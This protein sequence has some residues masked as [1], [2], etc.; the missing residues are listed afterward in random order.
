VVIRVVGRRP[1]RYR[2]GADAALDRPAHVRAASAIAWIG[3]QLV[4]VQDDSAFLAVVDPET[5]LCDDLPLPPCPAGR[6]VFD[7]AIGNKRDKPDLESVFADGETMIALGSGGPIAARQII[8]TWR[9]GAAPALVAAPRLFDALAAATCPAGTSLNLE[10]ALLDGATVVL[11]NRGGDRA[12][13][14]VSPDALIRLDLAALRALI[15]DPDGAPVP[16]PTVEPV[17]LGDLDGAPLHFTDLAPGPGGP[18]FAAVAEATTSYFTDGAVTGSVIGP[19]GALR[20]ARLRGPDKIEGLAVDRRGGEGRFLCVT[21]PD[22]P[23]RP[24]ELLEVVV[25]AS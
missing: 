11:A 1:L 4:V 12:G 8:V 24:G 7:Q 6:R 19:L 3:D 9:P 25:S 2:R 16:T 14:A 10:G 21:D 5:G 22:D 23:D 18:W 20:G 17:E 15:A 13:D